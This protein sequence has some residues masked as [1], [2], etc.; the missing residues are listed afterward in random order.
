MS[1][2][3]KLS[4]ACP[5]YNCSKFFSDTF[6]S[7]INQIDKLQCDYEFIICDDASSDGTEELCRNLINAHKG[8]HIRYYRH[9]NNI[10]LYN[11]YN[12]LFRISKGEY[13]VFPSHDDK[14]YNDFYFVAVN[15]LEKNPCIGLVYSHSRV[16]GVN[17]GK[18]LRYETCHG[19]GV[20]K[21]SYKRFVNTLKCLE[22]V[23]VQGVF[24]KSILSKTDLFRGFVGSDHILLNQLSLYA[25]FYC[26]ERIDIDY[27][28]NENKYIDSEHIRKV[29]HSNRFF[30]TVWIYENIRSVMSYN[31]FSYKEKIKYCF[32]VVWLQKRLLLSDIY[33]VI[34]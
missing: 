18:I 21:T 5:V 14:V 3:I 29:S 8:Y 32:L 19:M 1:E 12:Y 20:G 16:I 2:K 11:N 13:I 28:E 7:L 15:E 26:T 9:K 33:S 17:S 31:E 30:K 24:R 22:T 23:A 10:G 4:I 25:G 27:Y 6:I 34:K